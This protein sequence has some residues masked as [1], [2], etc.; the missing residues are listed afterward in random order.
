[1]T[2]AMEYKGF[3]GRVVYDDHEGDFIGHLIGIPDV[4]TFCGRSVKELQASFRQAVE[5]YLAD[6]KELGKEARPPKS[7]NLTLRLD[8]ELHANVE[9]Q[10]KLSGKSLNKWA[11][12]TLE[13]AARRSG[14]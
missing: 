10:A 12:D 13:A 8:P 9:I 7:G 6:C 5:D 2:K 4:I 3:K 1:M 11:K 14:L